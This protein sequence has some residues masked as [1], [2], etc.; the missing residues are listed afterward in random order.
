MMKISFPR[1]IEHLEF[2]FIHNVNSNVL[3]LILFVLR[4]RGPGNNY[5]RLAIEA[6]DSD[7]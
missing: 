7:E 1:C 5:F 2:S 3:P 6:R 4:Y